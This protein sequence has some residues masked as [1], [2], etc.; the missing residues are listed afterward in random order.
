MDAS[1]YLGLGLQLAVAMAFFTG[2][3]YL[4]DRWL[5]TLPWLTIA[6]A[7]VGM[8]GVFF[9]I[10]RVSNELARQKRP[11]RD[12]GDRPPPDR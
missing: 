3:G 7:A 9:Q 6:G 2:I 4:L 11:P 1:P 10:V 8:V 12:G 5:G